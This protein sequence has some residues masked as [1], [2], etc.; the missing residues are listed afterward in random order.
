MMRKI[1]SKTP[2]EWFKQA[3]YDVDTA[4]AMFK[5]G[6]YIYTV[7]LCHLSIEKALKGLYTLKYRDIPP[8]IHNLIYLTKKIGLLYPDVLKEF[9]TELN[10][11]SIP[12]RY[13]E[14]LKVLLVEYNKYRASNILRNTKRTLKWLKGRLNK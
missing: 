5:S 3:V 8:K 1:K 6:R 14:E 12:T 13:P 7:F 4:D 10:R 11:V 9:V 2:E